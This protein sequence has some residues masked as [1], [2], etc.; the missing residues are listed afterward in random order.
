M[1]IVGLLIVKKLIALNPSD[2]RPIK[3]ILV[4][5]PI[6]LPLNLPLLEAL[7][8]FTNGKARLGIV[9][10]SVTIV[11]DCLKNK[12]Q[13][14]AN[15]HMAGIITMH[16]IFEEIVKQELGDDE[17]SKL[18]NLGKQLTEGMADAP[19]FNQER[20]RRMT[21]LAHTMKCRVSRKRNK[22]E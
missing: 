19:R 1:A 8:L 21:I 13:I 9:T 22:R 5:K 2:A 10:D 3:S 18:N 12:K 4:R 16:D 14:P 17:S 11:Q 20:L 15:V 6:V 7:S